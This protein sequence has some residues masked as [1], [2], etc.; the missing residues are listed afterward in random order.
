MIR[1][2]HKTLAP[3]L[4]YPKGGCSVNG[5]QGERIEAPWYLAWFWFLAKIYIEGMTGFDGGGCRRA[6]GRGACT[7]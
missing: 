3:K 7:P 2:G 1:H 6:A 4:A 5:I